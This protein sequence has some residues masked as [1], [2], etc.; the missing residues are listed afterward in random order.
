MENLDIAQ[1]FNREM[2]ERRFNAEH[3][4]GRSIARE[5]L[6]KNKVTDLSLVSLVREASFMYSALQEL[7]LYHS[8]GYFEN[9][10]EF[11]TQSMPLIPQVMSP[12]FGKAFA[13]LS[14]L[15][16][17]KVS[18]ALGTPPVFL[19]LGSGRG[20]LDNDMIAYLRSEAFQNPNTPEHLDLFRGARF[21]VSDRTQRALGYLRK[22]L[23]EHLKGDNVEIAE[24]NAFNFSVGPFPYGIV[25]ANELLD[26]MPVEPIVMIEK[27]PYAVRLLPSW[28]G[29]T[30]PALKPLVAKYPHLDGAITEAHAHSMI[31]AGD[32]DSLHFNPVAIP[33]GWDEDVIKHVHA[34]MP[35]VYRRI[36][37]PE[38]GGI[39]PVQTRL[40]GLFSSIKRSFEHAQI[41]LVDMVANKGAYHNWN[42]A[43]NIFQDYQFGKYDL[44]FY[45]DP[46]QVYLT[47][48]RCGITPFQSL[49][50]DYFMTQMMAM[51]NIFT[52][53][54]VTRFAA[55]N[56]KKTGTPDKLRM[57]TQY[58]IAIELAC[59]YQEIMMM[60]Y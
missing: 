16:Y 55:L 4:K 38:F 6:E 43:V 13:D 22:E 50:L 20:I 33:L 41:M 28:Q 32:S 51:V 58:T 44:D 56:S 42:N 29:E 60:G 19:G 59:S 53:A 18:A 40:R 35:L 31:D 2:R 46:E 3:L 21:I 1:F 45:I 48:Q 37:T 54:D 12:L 5:I 23:E 52:P 30:D 26:N 25:Y 14:F 11:T 7:T 49:S 36:N 10:V 15:V 47:G 57:P 24:L 9:E 39:Y 17:Q 34:S 27:T 8:T